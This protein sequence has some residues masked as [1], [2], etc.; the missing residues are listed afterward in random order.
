MRDETFPKSE[1]AVIIAANSC[2]RLKYVAVDFHDESVYGDRQIV[3]SVNAIKTL[4]PEEV[5]IISSNDMPRSITTNLIAPI[6]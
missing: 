4:R 1:K 2:G 5:I 6:A 3:F